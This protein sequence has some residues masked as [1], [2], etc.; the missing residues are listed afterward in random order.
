MKKTSLN[1]G[2]VVR[3]EDREVCVAAPL[4]DAIEREPRADEW[5]VFCTGPRA[6]RGVH[7][8]TGNGERLGCFPKAWSEGDEFG[9]DVR[10]VL[11]KTASHGV[12]AHV[13]C[14]LERR[15]LGAKIQ[16]YA[17][18]VTSDRVARRGHDIVSCCGEW[19]ASSSHVVPETI[20]YTQLCV[21]IDPVWVPI[22]PADHAMRRERCSSAECD[23]VRHATTVAAVQNYESDGRIAT[24]HRAT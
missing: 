8:A 12:I 13:V 14:S 16:G 9:L 10:R 19:C 22:D 15:V 20:R 11:A 24:H 2:N 18:E 6:M 17:D 21:R 4:S 23:P 5:I 3:R 1:A 7:D